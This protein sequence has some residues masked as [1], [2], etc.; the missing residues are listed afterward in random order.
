MTKHGNK[1]P[2]L[3]SGQVRDQLAE[4]SDGKA[5]KR[6]AAAREYM[7]GHSPAE[8]ETKYGWHKQTVYGWLNR[9]E[10]R[11]FE[12]ALYEDKPPGRSPE[13]SDAQFQQFAETLHDLPEEAGYNE[14]A[15]DA[16]LAQEYLLKTFGVAHS[17][18]H[19]S[20]L[21][22]EADM[23]Y[24]KPRPQP[25]TADEQERESS[26]KRLKTESET[27]T[28]MPSSSRSINCGKLSELISPTRGS[29]STS[30]RRLMCQPH[31]R[32][33]IFPGRSP[34]TARRCFWSV[35]A[36]SPR[37]SQFGSF[38]R[39]RKSSVGTSS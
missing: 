37:E 5:I 10:E 23:T 6:L 22:N 18:R 13:L 28:K 27:G 11:D 9:F 20:R 30:G 31:A 36:R 33:S 32:E 1:I 38:E 17:Q 14:P 12:D 35:I 29:R 15:W 2:S 3:D 4:E 34:N 8:I 21:M 19:V 24:K 26:T 16:P 39:F 7:A 25:T